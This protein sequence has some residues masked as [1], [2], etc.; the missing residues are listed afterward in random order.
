MPPLI[1]QSIGTLSP[2][3]CKVEGADS[4][5]CPGLLPPLARKLTK[6]C[7]L[8]P[9]PD[10]SCKSLQTSWLQIQGIPRTTLQLGNFLEQLT[11]LIKLYTYDYNFFLKGEWTQIKS[12]QRERC[13]G[14]GPG[15]RKGFLSDLGL[16]EVITEC[17]RQPSVGLHWVLSG[18]E[19][20]SMTGHLND[21]HL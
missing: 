11:E 3:N 8:P 13:T 5:V 9:T 6:L 21:F 2:L 18:S 10:T 15:G 16:C 20:E 14:R 19:G 17:S 4:Q 7:S 12:S 1:L